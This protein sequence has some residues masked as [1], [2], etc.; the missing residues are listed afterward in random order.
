[1]ERG[2]S[3]FVAPASRRGVLI[4]KY[5]AS[6]GVF[7]DKIGGR[8]QMYTQSISLESGW[9][10]VG[11]APEGGSLGPLPVMVPGQIH[12]DLVR[13]GY[14]PE[15]FWGKNAEACQWVEA[16]DWDYE[17][18][19]DLPVDWS[20]AWSVLRFE[21]LDNAASVCLNGVLLGETRN[22]F[23]PY[24]YE[25][26]GLLRARGNALAVRFSAI[27]K[28]LA[29]K[30]LDGY[31]SCFTQERVWLRKMQCG[32]SWD[33]LPRFVTY[34]IWRPVKLISFTEGRL[35]D[36]CIRTLTLAGGRAS[37]EIEV[38]AETRSAKKCEVECAIR[39]RDKRMLWHGRIPLAGGRARI[40][41]V[42]ERIEAWWPH[43]YGMQ[44]LYDL[45]AV[46]FCGGS[47]VDSR[48]VEF[49]IRTVGIEEIPD[50]R[51]STF[52]LV[53]N[54]ER[55][56]AKGGNWVPADP[57]PSR[58]STA[59]YDRLIRLA[60][61]AN[62]NLLRVWGGGINE[63]EDFWHA[64]NKY[65]VMI[66]QDFLL[67][68]AEY[69]EHDPAF[70]EEF[71]REVT[72]MVYTLR[73]HPSLILWSGNNELGMNSD[74]KE[75]YPGKWLA[76]NISGPIC[77]ELDP[78]RLFRMTSPYGGPKNN[79]TEAGDCHVSAYET[80]SLFTG[81]MS[82]YRQRIAALNGRFLSE[83]ACAG[84]PPLRTLLRFMTEAQIADPTDAMWNYHAM[85]NPY[86][87][88]H[89]MDY[90]GMLLHTAK[91]LF[92]ETGEPE[93]RVRHLEYV[94]YEWVRLTIESLRRKKFSSSGL[95]FWMYNDCWTAINWS[96]VDYYENPK[97]GWYACRRSFQPTIA[98]IE[99]C[100]GHVRL[101]ICNDSLQPVAGEL[102]VMA[103]TTR[104]GVCEFEM[105][106]PVSCPANGTSV[107]GELAKDRCRCLL[108][109]R[110]VLV[111]DLLLGDGRIDRACYFEGMPREM[112]L[113]VV[114]L[115]AQATTAGDRGS[116]RL[117]TDNYARVV[118]IE[119]DLVCEDN[120]FD[121]LP[122]ET[123]EIKWE[124]L[125]E[126]PALIRVHAWN[127]VT[128]AVHVRGS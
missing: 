24:E 59:K 77:R 66:T 90:Y 115:S 82:D 92:G 31:F 50:E 111:A 14:L 72:S 23:T 79:S 41:P 45:E 32:F 99:D 68:C 55:V 81:D 85:D 67:A 107:A 108:D 83:S 70:A 44:T 86:K 65:G 78:T 87:G 101:W 128:V 114:T 106:F 71:R 26:G 61:D 17:C 73:N 42:L 64:C 7:A 122:G 110:G 43:G 25:V 29:G 53:I 104:D 117:R 19:F 127:G 100:G 109:R 91:C 56:F 93:Q 49:G 13:A 102:R 116:I 58:I 10:A 15:P 48:T 5:A 51:G 118:T 28:Q 125:H 21:G 88:F 89:S 33:W 30:R 35:T 16:W 1:M 119:E 98:S 124:A 54:G 3:S 69:P 63:P 36:A 126:V 57:F 75:D 103:I 60:R 84:S 105:V 37:L 27:S 8:L 4:W 11:H 94:Q 9:H 97:A 46:L 40:Q 62:M 96:I 76:A 22:M 47:A 20:A 12:P 120:Y 121:L 38:E 80:E 113:P 95:Q 18:E 34:G 6:N 112:D 74:P 2:F 123:R 39:D 52:T